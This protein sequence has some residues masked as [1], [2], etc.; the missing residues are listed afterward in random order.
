MPKSAKQIMVKAAPLADPALAGAARVIREGTLRRYITE[1][2]KGVLVTLSGYYARKLASGELVKV[3]DVETA[4]VA[5]PTDPGI[6]EGA[7]DAI[8]SLTDD[9]EQ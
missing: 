3:A 5:Y 8:D 1:D 9:K 7:L 4:R 6:D 2:S